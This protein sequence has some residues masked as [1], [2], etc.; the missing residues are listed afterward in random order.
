MREFII[1]ANDANQRVDKYLSK[2]LKK[3]PKNLMY[4]YIRNKKIKVNRSRCEISQKLNEGDTVQM[5]ISEEFFDDE[6]RLNFLEASKKLDILYEDEHLLIVNKEANLLV[7]SDT[8][9]QKDSLIQRILRYLYEKNE[10]D[11]VNEKSFTPS[12]CHRIDRN[13]EGIVIAAK[14]AD[15]LRLMNEKIR[16]HEIEKHYLCIVEGNIKKHAVLKHY[17]MKDEKNNKAMLINEEKTGYVPVELEY[18]VI[19]QKTKYALVDVNLITG[20]S[21][22]IRAQ[23]AKT[24]HP[25]YGDLKYGAKNGKRNSQA[26]CAYK[27]IFKFKDDNLLGYLNEKTI[28]ID[29]KLKKEFAAL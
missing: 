12:L 18:E 2:S 8:E 23:F 6:V 7:H 9:E 22:Q 28:E 14:T 5:Y 3:L 19:E 4:K 29:S 1:N 24:G 10:Y 26:L 27:I 16:N 25:L 15:A 13:T 21:H 11:P 17:Y 20:K